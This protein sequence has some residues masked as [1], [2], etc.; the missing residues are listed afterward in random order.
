MDC[1]N[2]GPFVSIKTIKLEEGTHYAKEVC[3]E[4][5]F[6]FRWV[7]KPKNENNR[8]QNKYTAK[9]EGIDRCQLCRRTI[10]ML[11]KREVIDCHHVVEI[12]DGGTDTLDNIW[13]ACTS[14]HKDIHHNRT[15]FMKKQIDSVRLSEISKLMDEHNVTGESRT[16][17]ESLY[18]R[19]MEARTDG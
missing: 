7:P 4:C 18:I 3:A 13:W 10:D 5:N 12:Q 11:G 9:G 15:Y 2:C 19:V 14:C 1:P 8:K 16:A 6:F 17:L